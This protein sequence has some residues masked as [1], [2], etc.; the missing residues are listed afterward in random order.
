ML[1]TL[2]WGTPA[3]NTRALRQPLALGQQ[4][5]AGG[6]DSLGG[7]AGPAWQG[8]PLPQGS[9]VSPAPA[10]GP[11]VTAQ[12]EAEGDRRPTHCPS[13]QLLSVLLEKIHGKT[14]SGD[15]APRRTPFLT[16]E[17][18]GLVQLSLEI[19]DLIPPVQ[20]LEPHSG[21]SSF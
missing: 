11:A 2:P 13:E 5:G 20:A 18:L 3:Q 19:N 6:L 8:L 21:L 1:D 12:A 4:H 9:E 10:M 17:P 15:C 16:Q 7:H 14:L